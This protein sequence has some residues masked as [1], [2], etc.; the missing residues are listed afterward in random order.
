M[1]P[2]VELVPLLC[3]NCET[4]VPAEVDQVA[5]ACAQ[6]GQGLLLDAAEGLGPLDIHYARGIPSGK[7]GKPYW[8][9]SARVSLE[10]AAE[11]GGWFDRIEHHSEHFWEGERRFYVPAFTMSLDD[12]LDLSQEMLV[13]PPDL[14]EGPAVSFA[15]VSLSPTDLPALI[16]FIVLGIEAGRKDK[17]TS[18]D[19]SVEL[20]TPTLWILP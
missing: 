14:D 1:K 4:P 16:E 6:C 18:I 8:V 12:L 9:A 3:L 11:G 10:R 19:I 2:Q 7:T 20:D 5:W 15:P 13:N 17:V